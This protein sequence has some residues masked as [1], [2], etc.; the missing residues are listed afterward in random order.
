MTLICEAVFPSHLFAP[1]CILIPCEQERRKEEKKS[2]IEELGEVETKIDRVEQPSP[3]VLAS[4]TAEN[5]QVLTNQNTA[6]L[7]LTNQNTAFY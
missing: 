5:T 1:S 4:Q 6:L 3:A 2:K 7:I